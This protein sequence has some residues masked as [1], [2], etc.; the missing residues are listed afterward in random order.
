MTLC[1][2]SGVV[3][4]G[5]AGGGGNPWWEPLVGTLGG[6]SSGVMVCASIACLAVLPVFTHCS[7]GSMPFTPVLA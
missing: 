1:S 6:G 4:G 2:Q 5:G 3:S 7:V